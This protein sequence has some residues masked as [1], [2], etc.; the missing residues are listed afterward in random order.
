MY[1]NYFITAF[2]SLWKNKVFSAINILGLSIGISASL[3]IYLLVRYDFSFDKF[4]RDGERIYRVVS[5]FTFSGEYYSNS[6]ITVP[7]TKAVS[8]EIRGLDAT[9]P[10]YALNDEINVSV[11]GMGSEKPAV[12]RNQDHIAFADA[13]YFNLFQFQWMAGSPATSLQQPY[14]AVLTTSMAEQYFPK[15]SLQ[16][17]IGKR[18]YFNDTIQA[19]ITGI[20]QDLSGNTDFKLNTFISLSTLE[21]ARLR[22]DGYD[23]WQ[24]TNSDSQFFLKL[25]ANS[26]SNEPEV[27]K[28]I[29]ALFERLRTKD[30]D[31]KNSK[32]WFTLQPL[33]DIHF[34][35]TFG[36][37]GQRQAHKPTLYSLLAI[38][39]FLLLL[40]CINFINLTTAQASQRAREIGIRKTMGGSRLQLI[41]QFLSEAFLLTF[42]AALLSV[43]LTPLLL[44]SFR[45]FIPPGLHFSVRQQPDVIIFLLLLT[46]AVSLLSGFYPALILSGYKPVLVLKNQAF[47]STHLTRRVWLR[48]T[49][50]V[51]QF[52]VAQVFIIATILVG[53]QISYTLNK[54]I[55]MRKEGILVVRVSS[56][57]GVPERLKNFTE[58]LKATPE[59]AMVSLSNSPPS[60]SSSWSSTLKYNDGKKE[61][62][63]NVQIKVGDT[64]YIKLYQLKLLSGRNILRNDSVAGEVMINETYAHMLGFR[65]PREA[66][67]KYLEWD[68][69][70]VLI[71]GVLSDFHLMSLRETIKPLAIVNL[72]DRLHAVNILL[73]PQD[74][75]G[76]VW[77]TAIKKIGEEW[78]AVYPEDDFE[79]RFFDEQLAGYYKAEQQI[80]KLLVWST[81]L[82]VFISCLGLLGLVMYTT[83]RRTKEIGV[84]KVLGASVTQIVQ[85]LSKD[86]IVLVVLALLIAIPIAW[87][88]VHRWLQNFAYRTTISWWVFLLTGVIMLIIALLTLGIQTMKA[89]MAN[90][91]RSLRTE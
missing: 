42:T 59:I 27:A 1:R 75:K 82:A 18:I 79:Y 2:R 74:E 10:Y 17:V 64:N 51:S 26:N 89:A 73:R 37:F 65:Q 72:S 24:S 28:Q 30:P 86:F 8:Q 83:A 19:T 21:S 29:N 84:R 11:P 35:A 9:A 85:L 43:L 46:L 80:S 44:Q 47:A 66:V 54:D 61:L 67:G 77:K 58:K 4:H 13:R 63:H 36:A 55:G 76:T 16:Q 22:P 32:T 38:A 6:G 23:D 48:K 88:G 87:I 71:C 15:L 45:D 69:R 62:E 3:V 91:M 90:P 41:S 33:S 78:K 40:G 57:K 25:S 5:N 50:T 52:V 34:N 7:L 81:G 70:N 12:F 53:K 20:V 56:R 39:G 49:L 60:S 31:D 14:Q 68:K